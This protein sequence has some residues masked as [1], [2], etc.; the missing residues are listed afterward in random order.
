M[1]GEVCSIVEV[2][3]LY[4]DADSGRYKFEVDIEDGI[5][6]KSVMFRADEDTLNAAVEGKLMNAAETAIFVSTMD[7]ARQ[8]WLR[9]TWSSLRTWLKRCVNRANRAAKMKPR[10]AL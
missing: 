5:V 1:S 3:E 8:C 6:T 9:E 7:A 2:F 10:A 4:I